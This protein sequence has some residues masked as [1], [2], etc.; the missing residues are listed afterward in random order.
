[1]TE[2][3]RQETKEAKDIELGSFA[4]LRSGWWVL[5]IVAIAAVFYLGWMFGGSIFR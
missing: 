5:H 3:F 4:F 1:M 2:E